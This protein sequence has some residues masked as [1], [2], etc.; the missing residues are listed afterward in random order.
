MLL[1]ASIA[2]GN[3][4]AH[5]TMLTLPL[6]SIHPRNSLVS[7][8]NRTTDT[9]TDQ[10][11]YSADDRVRRM[12]GFATAKTKSPST[13]SDSATRYAVARFAR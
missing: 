2:G 4:G 9:P 10:Y 12:P 8:N 13:I 11:F 1:D 7:A 3:I 6:R 5:T